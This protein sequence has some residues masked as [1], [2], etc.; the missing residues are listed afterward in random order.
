[1]PAAKKILI[2]EDEPEFLAGLKMRLE[3]NGYEV[4]EASDGASGLETARANSPDLILLDLM[5]PKIDGFKV[6]SQLKSD[7]KHRKIPIIMLTARSQQVDRNMGMTVGVD[8]YLTKPFRPKV[9]LDTIER[10]IPHA[11]DE[12]D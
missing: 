5:I 3:A 4:L 10:L 6:A 11:P 9:L 2:I 7:E 8:D 1:M 12:T